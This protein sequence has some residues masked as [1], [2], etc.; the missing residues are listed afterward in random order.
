VKNNIVNVGLIGLGRIGKMHA[1]NIYQRLPFLNLKS[2]ADPKPDVEFIQDIG[3]VNSFENPEKIIF[4]QNIDAVVISSPTPTHFDLIN[5]CIKNNKHVFCEKPI[6]F[7]EKEINEIIKLM[8]TQ[9]TIVQVGL[10]RRFDKEFI[11]LKNKIEEGLIG[12]PQM[13]HITNH[14][15]AIPKFKFLK[16]SGGMLF[17]LCIHD[18]DMLTFITGENIKEIYVNGAVFIE[19]RLKDIKDIDNAIITLELT[20]GIL[21]TIDSSRQTHFG[22]DQ[23]IEVFGSEGMLSVENKSNNLYLLSGKTKTSKSKINESFIERYESSYL[24]ELEYFYKSIINKGKS[25]VGPENILN[26]IRVASAGNES[27]KTNKPVLVENE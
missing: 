20:N 10:N 16:S 23:R 4:D 24:S 9:N 17:D 7:S 8:K 26:A 22:Y 3:R 1:K 13:I 12:E 25:T 19:Q 5:K 2:V 6:S 14:D 11:L 21:C 15:S 18:F 27:I